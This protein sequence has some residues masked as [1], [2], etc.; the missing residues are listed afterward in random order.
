MP[1]HGS[2]PAAVQAT[3]GR[4]QSKDFE[5]QTLRS[6]SPQACGGPH[7]DAPDGSLSKYPWPAPPGGGQPLW[8]GQ[9]F[10]V[11]ERH[12][13]VLSYAI[14]TSGWTDELTSFHEDTAGCSHPIDRASRRTRSAN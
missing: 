1:H 11:G 3:D 6:V 14:A 9:G 7:G 5:R 12:C 2:S 4:R 13:P 8:T 10:R